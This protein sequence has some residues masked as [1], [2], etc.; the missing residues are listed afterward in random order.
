MNEPS[1][2]GAMWGVDEKKGREMGAGG[3]RDGNGG[4]GINPSVIS[5]Q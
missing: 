2:G 5:Y 3:I 4:G 1:A